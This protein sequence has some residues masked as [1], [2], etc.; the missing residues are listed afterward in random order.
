MSIHGIVIAIV[1][2]VSGCD[3]LFFHI[4]Q[5]FISVEL[6]LKNTLLSSQL[7]CYGCCLDINYQR[8]LN[9][10]PCGSRWVLYQSGLW[11]AV[12][13]GVCGEELWGEGSDLACMW[14]R[15][16]VSGGGAAPSGDA[17]LLSGRAFTQSNGPLRHKRA[18]VCAHTDTHTHI[19]FDSYI[20]TYVTCR[21]N[22]SNIEM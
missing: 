1:I 9:I 21:F 7:D 17:S 20:H 18:R 19:S 16:L 15:L 11:G 10:D 12:L 5:T 13:G 22:Q 14:H 6:R 2:A 8:L 4:G 3:L